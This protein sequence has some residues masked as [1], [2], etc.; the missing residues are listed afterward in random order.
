MSE[1]AI[2]NA[3]TPLSKPSD[4]LVGIFQTGV[5]WDGTEHST[6]I[7]LP[8]K[9]EQ[10]SGARGNISLLTDV[11]VRTN[12]TTFWSLVDDLGKTFLKL[13]GMFAKKL[14]TLNLN[15]GQTQDFRSFIKLGRIHELSALRLIAEKEMMN[16]FQDR[17]SPKGGRRVSHKILGF[18]PVKLPCVLTYFEDDQPSELVIRHVMNLSNEQQTRASIFFTKYVWA[19]LSHFFRLK[20]WGLIV[21]LYLNTVSL[22]LSVGNEE[23]SAGVSTVIARLLDRINM[24]PY[25]FSSLDVAGYLA[26]IMMLHAGY[27]LSA[28]R[29]TVQDWVSNFPIQILHDFSAANAAEHYNGQVDLL[30]VSGW[31]REGGTTSISSCPFFTDGG[32]GKPGIYPLTISDNPDRKSTVSI[33]LNWGGE[34]MKQDGSVIDTITA[35]FDRMFGWMHDPQAEGVMLNIQKILPWM[36]LSAPP[37]DKIRSPIEYWNLYFYTVVG[38]G[39]RIIDDETFHPLKWFVGFESFLPG[40][41]FPIVIDGDRSISTVTGWGQSKREHVLEWLEDRAFALTRTTLGA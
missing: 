38:T 10:M 40:N 22:G 31:K 8:M 19:A 27:N 6:Y 3:A 11:E 14:K 32:P 23:G 17:Y 18:G 15:K 21:W 33:P 9:F 29:L 41:G 35:D 13:K 1:N 16:F 37:A 20:S 39:M 5:I 30:S 2:P 7:N 36:F 24:S 34:N 4:G 26:S 28:E 12:D 25:D